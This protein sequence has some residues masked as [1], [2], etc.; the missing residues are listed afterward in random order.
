[1]GPRRACTWSLLGLTV[2]LTAIAYAPILGNEFINFDDLDLIVENPL[3]RRMDPQGLGA[4]FREQIFTPHYKPLVYVTWAVEY[5]LVG[6]SPIAFHV[7]NLLLH[8]ANCILIFHAALA[9]L[10]LAGEAAPRTLLGAAVVALFFGVHP[11]HVESVAW[12]VQRKDVLFTAFFLLGLRS[13]LAFA[14]EGFRRRRHLVY[15]SLC[16]L[17]AI[18]SK[19]AGITFA[20]VPFLVDDLARRKLDRRSLLE[21]VPIGAIALLAAVLYGLLASGPARSPGVDPPF[22]VQNLRFLAFAAHIVLPVRLS[23]IYPR[24]G[25]LEQSA[26]LLPFLPL[27]TVILLAAVAWSRRWSRAPTFAA[28]FFLATLS[29][30][31]AMPGG[32]TNFLSDRYTY[33]PSLGLFFLLSYGVVR[34]SSPRRLRLAAVA[35][36][37]LAGLFAFQTFQRC[38]VWRDGET[39]WSDTIAKFPGQVGEAYVNRGNVYLAQNRLDAALDDYEAALQI[40]PRFPQA[41]VGRG[42]VYARTGRLREAFECFDTAVRLDRD[43]PIAR[44]QRGM[45]LTLLGDFQAAEED[46]ERYLSLIRD[47][48]LPYFWRGLNR[49]AR[50]LHR[51]AIDDFTSAIS[52]DPTHRKAYAARARS[53][54]AMGSHAE[55]AKDLA[56]LG[57][58]E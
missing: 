25:L 39:L 29:P 53:H 2:L 22:L 17:G 52:L 51:L 11:L 21:K 12:A 50:G 43:L 57:E 24:N 42:A 26:A 16:Y 41:L 40:S 9:L 10:R 18:L 55:A 48:P 46:Y 14:E 15:C 7:D 47:D 35:C 1:M 3:L 34:I 56:L 32:G 20:A 27:V 37:A 33:L 44:L 23:V 6:L 28:G 58:L 8:L 13:Y 30:V 5:H 4:I 31:V 19:G 38:Q 49:Q 45:S 36:A 54:E